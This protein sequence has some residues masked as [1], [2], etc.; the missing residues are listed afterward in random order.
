MTDWRH[1]AYNAGLVAAS[2]ALAVWVAWRLLVRGK[3]RQ[4]LAERLGALPEELTRLAEADD[5]VVWFHAVSVGE[6]GVADLIIRE[7]RLAEPLCHVVLSTT[8]ATGRQMAEKRQVDV[9]GKFYFPFDVLPVVERVLEGLRPA[10]IVL[11][12]GELWPNLL[13]AAK[14][15]GVKVAVVNGRISDGAFARARLV[16]P[17]YR[18]IL[19]NVDLICAQSERDAERF[20]ALGAEPGRVAVMGNAKFDEK[21]PEVS[22]AEAARLRHEFGF[23]DHDPVFVAGSTH[24]GEERAVLEAFAHLRARHPRL[25]L[26]LAPRHPERGDQIHRLVEQFGFSVYRRSQAVQGQPQPQ[27]A[28]PQARVV[29][30]DTIGELAKVYALADVVFVGGSLV[31]IGGHNVLEPLAQGKP[32]LTGP[33]T[34]NFRDIMALALAADA[35]QIVRNADE[36]AGAVERLL[37]D[38]GL[39]RQWGERA[40]Q[41]LRQQRGASK[42]MAEALAGLLSGAPAAGEATPAQN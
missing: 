12:E 20:L 36:L 35:V 11:V 23:E 33:H 7:F 42:R 27:P 8:T 2:P 25:Q 13:A 41:L 37:S 10:M 9:E 26:V 17:L 19:G 39:R 14:G 40:R 6:V 22:P 3:G 15:R 32:V 18:W 29:I 28:G 30:L 4:G 5:P 21:F 34:H 38:A 16:R 1:V 31:P 24:E